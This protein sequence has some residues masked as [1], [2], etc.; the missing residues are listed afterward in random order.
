MH[1]RDRDNR[2][3]ANNPRENRYVNRQRQREFSEPNFEPQTHRRN[4]SNS[5]DNIKYVWLRFYCEI[6]FTKILHLIRV[7]VKLERVESP[8]PRPVVKL[9]RRESPV[10]LERRSRSRQRSRS[11][12]P[13]RRKKRDRNSSGRKRNRSKRDK[14]SNGK[15]NR[16]NYTQKIIHGSIPRK[17]P[18]P[19]ANRL[20]SSTPTPNYTSSSITIPVRFASSTLRNLQEEFLKLSER[21]KNKLDHTWKPPNILRR[22]RAAILGSIK[23]LKN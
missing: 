6:F 7:E 23:M 1:P 15:R 14:N 2:Y 5:N 18:T 3:H 21:H 12:S 8:P 10:K 20:V 9:E 22:K 19:L 16:H 13:D 4:S 17:P 11:R